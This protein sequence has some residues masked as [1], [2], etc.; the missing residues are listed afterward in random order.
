MTPTELQA[1]VEELER[2]VRKAHAA[3][4]FLLIYKMSHGA[5]CRVKFAKRILRPLLAPAKEPA[6]PRR[7]KGNPHD[8]GGPHGAEHD[9]TPA[10][11]VGKPCTPVE[12]A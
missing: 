1:R 9:E 3:I 7:M 8:E 10:C 5:R 4:D 11:C 6:K 12:G 2:G